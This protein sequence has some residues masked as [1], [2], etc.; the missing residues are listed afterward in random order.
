MIIIK[1]KETYFNNNYTVTS[2]SRLDKELGIIM[3]NLKG[4]LKVL[5]MKDLPHNN[6]NRS[7][8]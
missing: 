8:I 1:V 2:N 7:I 5:G 3:I 6:S 4:F